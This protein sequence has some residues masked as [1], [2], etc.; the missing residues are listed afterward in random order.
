MAVQS[1]RRQTSEFEGKYPI[2]TLVRADRANDR[3]RIV[4]RFGIDTD[5]IKLPEDISAPPIDWGTG[6]WS[7]ASW[8]DF[9]ANGFPWKTG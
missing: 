6:G 7:A 4:Y 3:L 1:A 2:N 9:Y 5:P 8:P